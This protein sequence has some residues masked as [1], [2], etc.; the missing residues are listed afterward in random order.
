MIKKSIS[1]KKTGFFEIHDK[2]LQ[3]L[4]LVREEELPA[5]LA[6]TEGPFRGVDRV[7]RGLDILF[8]N[9]AYTRQI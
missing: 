4:D 3:Y 1:S 2:H 9:P 7:D 5:G 6:G 8:T